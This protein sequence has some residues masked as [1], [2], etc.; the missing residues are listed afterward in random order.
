MKNKKITYVEGAIAL[1]D[2]G[3]VCEVAKRALA[4]LNYVT[5]LEH[6]DDCTIINI[7]ADV[8]KHFD[9]SVIVY[10]DARTTVWSITTAN[11]TVGV[12]E[13]GWWGRSAELVSSINNMRFSFV[14]EFDRIPLAYLSPDDFENLI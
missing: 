9:C 6:N 7:S 8:G 4:D 11:E 13:I 12:D 1:K 3:Y 14:D 10:D 2:S 5:T